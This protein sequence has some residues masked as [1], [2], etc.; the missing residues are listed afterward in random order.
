[1]PWYS[2]P[3]LLEHLE[4]VDVSPAADEAGMRLPVQW[5]CRPDQDFR[6]F[7]GTLVGGTVVPGQRTGAPLRNFI[8][9]RGWYFRDG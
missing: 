5:V 1:M 8:S 7:A 2:G 4:T 6:G 9:V 3:A